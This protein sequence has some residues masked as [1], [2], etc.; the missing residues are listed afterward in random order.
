[1]K[2]IFSF[3]LLFAYTIISLGQ[4]NDQVKIKPHTDYLK[5]SK[6]QKTVAWILTG[7]GVATVTI[8]LLTQDY[9]DS[10]SGIAEEKNSASPAVY[11]V[12]GACIAGG[13]VLFVASSRNKKKANVASV[14]INMEKMPMFQEGAANY[15]A[16][17][18]LGFRL[19]MK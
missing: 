8:G 18:A 7:V 1:M 19:T 16:Y 3:T 14:S 17:P 5:K 4:Q 12:G 13:I 10:F 9:V 11:A 15:K 2:K 6:T